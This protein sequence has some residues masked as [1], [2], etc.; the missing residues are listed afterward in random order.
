MYYFPKIV[1]IPSCPGSS[2]GPW[3]LLAPAAKYS[4]LA[5]TP[6]LAASSPPQGGGPEVQGMVLLASPSLL[7][8]T[9]P[10]LQEALK[11]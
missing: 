5:G 6:C 11:K 8:S 2:E 7:A 3:E 9:A 4:Y 10:T 1:W